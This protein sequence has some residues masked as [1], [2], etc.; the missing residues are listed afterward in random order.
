M[1]MTLGHT[2]KVN[3]SELNSTLYKMFRD[4][5]LTRDECTCQKC[6]ATHSLEVHH[7]TPYNVDAVGAFMISN[8][9]TLCRA[10]HRLKE[11][12]FHCKYGTEGTETDLAEFIGEDT[13]RFIIETSYNLAQEQAVID[14]T[15]YELN[16]Q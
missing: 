4:A 1:E 12:G 15:E 14:E 11:T 8:G 16:Q 9:I 5:T 3:R 13:Y 2:T 10:C 7:M 6:G